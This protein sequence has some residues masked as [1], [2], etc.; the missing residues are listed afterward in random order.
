MTPF[1]YFKVWLI[2]LQEG[3]NGNDSKTGQ[4]GSVSYLFTL[5]CPDTRKKENIIAE[6]EQGKSVRC[7]ID[8]NYL[9]EYEVLSKN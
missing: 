1:L 4:P 8:E 3:Q 2:H 5:R 9:K 6:R 7:K